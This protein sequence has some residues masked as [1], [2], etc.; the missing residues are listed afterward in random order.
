MAFFYA[1]IILIA[2]IGGFSSLQVNTV[3]RCLQDL[4]GISPITVGIVFALLTGFTILGGVKKIASTTSKLI[5]IVTGL[6][7]TVCM[8]FILS[9]LNQVPQ[10]FISILNS[11]LNVRSFGIG[12]ISTLLIGMQKGIFSSEVGLGTGS[13]V[14][15][16][17]DTSS[18]SQSGLTQTFGIHIE[19]LV[20]AS[21]T[22]FVILLTNYNSLVLRRSE[23]YRNYFICFSKSY[24]E[25]HGSILVSITITLFALATVIAGY[26][27]GESSLK[28][29]KQKT[30]KFDIF[31][32]K[33]T[34]LIIIIIG[35]VVS[36]K[37]LWQSIDILVAIIAIINIYSLFAL[38]DVVIEEYK[39][40]KKHS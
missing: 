22:V 8:Y 17:A 13:I 30:T 25:K 24:A 23:W 7:V 15:V 14:A 11:A 27:Y 29:L 18:P 34:S 37:S 39:Y 5:P 9:H 33:V 19:N 32:L 1:F 21:I 10:I 38:K 36:S 28:Y 31:C 26:Y 40:W 2:Y 3:S 4:Y 6:Y 12:T 16:T 20:I 35:S